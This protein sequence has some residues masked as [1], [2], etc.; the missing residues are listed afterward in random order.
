MPDHTH[1]FIG[2]SPTIALSDLVRDVKRATSLWIKEQQI[3]SGPFF[4]QEGFGAFTY[5]QS[6]IEDVVRYV[7][8]QEEHHKKRTFRDEYL[9]LLEK[10][11]VSFVEEYL[12]DFYDEKSAY[13]I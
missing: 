6:Q 9:T 10:F 7:L 11:D 13:E 8:N 3:V 2:F 12:F 1:L 4:W 5:G